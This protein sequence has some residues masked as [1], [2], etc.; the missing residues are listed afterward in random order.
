MNAARNWKTTISGI[1][2]LAFAGL[3]IWQ[4]PA[5]ASDPQVI[6]AIVAGIGLIAAKDGDKSGTSTVPRP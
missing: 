1:M 4:Q 5:S 6:G 2:T 3:S